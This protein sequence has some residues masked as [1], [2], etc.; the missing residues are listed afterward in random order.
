MDDPYTLNTYM[1]LKEMNSTSSFNLYDYI[2]YE[3]S[4]KTVNPDMFYAIYE[5]FWPTFIIHKEHVILKEAFNHKYFEELETNSQHIEYWMNFVSIDP[6]FSEINNPE[7][8]DNESYEKC[9]EF[10]RKLSKLWKMKL[11]SDFPEKNFVVDCLDDE[12]TGDVALTFYQKTDHLSS[13]TLSNH[14]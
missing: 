3:F 10:T 14:C 1:K 5:L 13:S 12:D 11:T 8:Q 4:N 9:R 6:Y 7:S 2:Y